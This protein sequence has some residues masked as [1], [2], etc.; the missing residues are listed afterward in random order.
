MG[1]VTCSIDGCERPS[2]KRT[3]CA[4][5]Y[6]RWHRHGDPLLTLAPH[7]EQT[8]EERFWSKVA[9]D[10]RSE[11][12]IWQ[13]ARLAGGYGQAAVGKHRAT[14]AHRVSWEMAN[15]MRVPTGMFVCHRCDNPPCV[16]PY[17]LFLGTPADNVRDMLAKGRNCRGEALHQSKLTEAQVK[18]VKARAAAGEKQVRIAESVGASTG[19]VSRIV[20][21][22]IWR[23]VS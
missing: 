15:G 23:H 4:M 7:R 16:N 18:E 20:N 3:W 17:H 22:H 8:Y 11:C 6:G 1:K 13:A 5:H 19:T 10:D 2:R 9:M 14:G 12:W 21:G